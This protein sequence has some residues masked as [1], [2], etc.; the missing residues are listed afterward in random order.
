MGS[1]DIN[2]LRI[3]QPDFKV[4]HSGYRLE[5]T[6]LTGVDTTADNTSTSVELEKFTVDATTSGNLG[7][8]YTRKISGIHTSISDI[9]ATRNNVANTVAEQKVFWTKD[10]RGRTSG[11]DDWTIFS[12]DGEA[13]GAG[14]GVTDID[15]TPSGTFNERP[16]FNG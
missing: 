2:G 7:W 6:S 3:P 5:I 11:F 16:D 1:R 9:E 15:I 13:V 12:A 10:D 14:E 8:E 4:H